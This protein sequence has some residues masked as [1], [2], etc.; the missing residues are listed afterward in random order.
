MACFV[1]LLSLLLTFAFAAGLAQAQIKLTGDVVDGK[2]VIAK[3]DV[4]SL[5]GG[6]VHKFFFHPLTTA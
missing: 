1:V 2:P 5:E 4:A 3:L 6:K